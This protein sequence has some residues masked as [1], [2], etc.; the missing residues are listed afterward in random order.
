MSESKD[1]TALQSFSDVLAHLRS[2]E[3]SERYPTIE[4]AS[5][6]GGEGAIVL[7]DRRGQLGVV[8]A[9]G[10]LPPDFDALLVVGAGEDV[11]IA[12]EQLRSERVQML[13]LP[14]PLRLLDA[15]IHHGLRIARDCARARMVD[16]LLAVGAGLNAERDP[17]RVL[18]QILH[19]ARSIVGADAGSLYLVEEGGDS[20][21][22][23]YAENDSVS[24]DFTEFS[25]EISETSIVGACVLGKQTINLE[26]LYLETGQVSAGRR[27]CHDRSFDRRVGYETRSMLTVPMR[28]PGGEVSGVIQLINARRGGELSGFDGAPAEG[29]KPLL[30]PRHFDEEVVPFDVEAEQLCEA[31]AAQGAVALESAR[32]YEE[33]K[34]LFEGFVRA[35]VTAIER[36]DPTT[37]GHSQRVAQLTVTLAKHV[38]GLSEGPFAARKFSRDEIRELEYAALLHDFGK[39]AVRED[40]L[41]KA[42][43]LHPMQLDL[44]LSRFE[45]MRTRVQVRALEAR[46]LAA[47][48]ATLSRDERESVDAQ[49]L[50]TLGADQA[51]I[52]AWIEIVHR[53]NEPTVLEERCSHGLHDIQ[54]KSFSDS[55]GRSTLLL[56]DEEIEAL[57]I[58]RGSLTVDE[59]EEIQNHVR[60]TFAFLSKIP[61]GTS[62][63]RVPEIAGG[64]HEYLN[65]SGYPSQRSADG[66][67]LQTRMMTI[68]DIFDALTASDRPYKKAVPVDRAFH[69]LH[70]EAD[71]GKIDA[72]LL[73]I[74]E[75]ANI[76]RCIAAA[77]DGG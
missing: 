56:A 9:G 3:V 24:A 53:A 11:A 5:V 27:F 38:D 18:K 4:I 71:R 54:G 73:Q 33:V 62:L 64:H 44:A 58:H 2:A 28:P 49:A 29:R 72:R 61:W 14:C 67:S 75:Q 45:H 1:T 60:H 31:L 59:R 74:F 21:R 70:M 26:N 25:V 42:K 43:K 16:K 37:S 63:A 17:S 34:K 46:L 30:N 77:V 32:L 6:G 22:F 20:L 48:S 19:E 15:A 36:R 35:S 69:I 10:T 41:I 66:I 23:K 76:H 40:V 55:R 50:E 57:L 65:G 8:H 7:G 12:L 51:E 39:V 47:Q 52:D 68:S 13:P